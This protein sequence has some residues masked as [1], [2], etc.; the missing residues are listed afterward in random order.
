MH[1]EIVNLHNLFCMTGFAP[2][3]K[4][5]HW[6]RFPRPP[7]DPKLRTVGEPMGLQHCLSFLKTVTISVAPGQLLEAVHIRMQPKQLQF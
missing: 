6:G 1:N 3:I 2:T 4:K 7:E 5:E